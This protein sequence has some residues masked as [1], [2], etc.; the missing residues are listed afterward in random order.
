MLC[1]DIDIRNIKIKHTQVLP[2]RH[3]QTKAVKGEDQL[4]QYYYNSLWSVLGYQNVQCAM[5]F[6]KISF[7]IRCLNLNSSCMKYFFKKKQNL[8]KINSIYLVLNIVFGTQFNKILFVFLFQSTNANRM[9]DFI[10]FKRNY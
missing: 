1:T 6:G 9:M 8:I 7:W 5:G 4:L 10:L 3:L 2:S